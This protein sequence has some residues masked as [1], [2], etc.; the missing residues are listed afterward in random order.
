MKQ[1]WVV[2]LGSSSL[3]NHGQSL[4]NERLAAWAASISRLMA[5]GHEIVLVSSGAVA[6]GMAHLGLDHRPSD[7]STLQAIAAIGQTDLVQSWRSEFAKFKIPAAQV[8][9]NHSDIS[10][11]ERYLNARAAVIVLL[12]LP[13]VPIVNENDSVVTD[14]IRFGDNDT[15]AALVANLIDADGVLLLTD[16][17][18]LFTAHPAKDAFAQ[19]VDEAYAD[20]DSLLGYVSS[21]VSNVG[22][23]GMTT[24]LSAAKLA[25]RSGARTVIANALETNVIERVV[26]GEQLG[27]SLKARA[28]PIRARKQWLAGHLKL[29][30]QLCVDAGARS[31]LERKG[32][33]LLPVGLIS[34]SGEFS[35]GDCVALID[36]SGAEFARGLVNFP[37][38]E[39]S[40]LCG[41]PSEEIASR[42][43]YQAEI[44]AIHRDNLVIV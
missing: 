33:S 17:D 34:V 9:L 4:L 25:A 40:K 21:D 18:G 8:L 32:A 27:T 19:L 35:R 23:G 36:E 2:K 20:D 16:Q 28:L 3:T 1:R 31:F 29:R 11:R 7:I 38:H 22:T 41:V 24:K 13:A 26:A 15:L 5:Q 10:N 37:S 14:E 43:G 6:S 39:L 42:L 12:G 30:G 44:E